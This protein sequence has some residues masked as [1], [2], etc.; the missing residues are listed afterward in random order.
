MTCGSAIDDNGSK[1][2][3]VL[4]RLVSA[5]CPRHYKTHLNGK[6]C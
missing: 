6:K 4:E 5:L 3:V 1:A 2:K